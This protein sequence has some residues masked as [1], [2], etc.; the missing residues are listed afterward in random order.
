MKLDPMKCEGDF[1]SNANGKQR[2]EFEE[3]IFSGILGENDIWY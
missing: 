1:N 2:T 3:A